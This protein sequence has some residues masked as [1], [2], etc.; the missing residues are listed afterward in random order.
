MIMNYRAPFY[1]I[2]SIHAD[3]H[4]PDRRTHQPLDR[5]PNP[6][7]DSVRLRASVKGDE[8]G[9]LTR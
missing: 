7:M 2:L 1:F 8:E 9:D 6:N 3:T 4:R 5:P